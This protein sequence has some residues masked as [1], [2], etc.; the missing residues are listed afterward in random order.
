MGAHG[1]LPDSRPAPNAPLPSSHRAPELREGRHSLSS[2]VQS[3][4]VLTPQAGDLGV[5]PQPAAPAARP[6]SQLEAEC[7]QALAALQ[8]ESLDPPQP[9]SPRPPT[10]LPAMVSLLE[11]MVPCSNQV[12]DSNLL[13]ILDLVIRTYSNGD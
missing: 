11:L 13:P 1:P 10:F 8:T 2:E 4:Q 5:V 3:P 6:V 9:E 12:P 7:S